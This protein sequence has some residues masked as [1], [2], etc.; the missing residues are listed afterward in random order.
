MD[1]RKP[2]I[3]KKFRKPLLAVLLIAA[4]IGG[5]V[6]AVLLTQTYTYTV[7]TGGTATISGPTTLDF[8]ALTGGVTGSKTF[9]SALVVSAGTTSSI[10]F[11]FVNP[12]TTW[13]TVFSGVTIEVQTQG[14]TPVKKVCIGLGSS[15]TA[16]PSSEPTSF[17]PSA[18]TSYDY[19]AFFT[20]AATPATGVILSTSW[21]A[22]AI[23]ACPTAPSLGTASTY[24]VLASS[25][26]TN[27][28][29]TIITGDLGLSPGTSVTGTPTV[30]GATNINNAAA[31]TAITDLTTALTAAQG[32]TST[33]TVAGDLGGLTLTCGVYKSTSSLGLTGTLTLDG[34]GNANAVFVIQMG[35]TLT[36]AAGA[37][38]VLINGAQAKNVF[39][40]VGSSATLG[41]T[42]AFK[43][44]IMALA[45]ITVGATTVIN[46]RVLAQTAA[47]TLAA[48]TITVPA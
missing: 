17:T 32:M 19:F 48:D 30:S 40:A 10:T 7:T 2:R 9:A 46:G 21:S 36:T 18:S 39:W 43:G 15:A 24:G 31:A 12:T 34:Q 22:T 25:T 29:T 35:S 16:C 11:A 28:G 8:G 42:N 13:N 41:A 4:A 27:T 37:N 23:A 26:I 5:V 44:T 20:V 1:T 14:A 47:I 6:A 38:V 45:S 33:Q 3:A